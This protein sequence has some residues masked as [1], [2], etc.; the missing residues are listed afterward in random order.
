M[1]D[2]PPN[3]TLSFLLRRFQEAG[4]RPRTRL[5]QNFLIDMN[6]QRVLL[7]TAL[8]GPEDVVLE[9]GTGTGALTALMAREAAAVVTVELDRQLFQL[10]GEELFELG[11]VTMLQADALENKNRLNPDV[12]QAVAAQLAAGPARR[13][14]LVANLPYQVATPILSNLL[15][16]ERP[17]ESMTCTVQKEVAERIIA[18]PGTKDYGA[19]AVWVQSQCRAELVRVLAPSV[20]WPRPKVSS[21]FLHLTLEPKR[22][23]AI[24]DV[25]F[26]HD[27]VRAVF[28]HRR[29]LL[30]GEI[31]AALGRQATKPDADRLLAGLGLSATARAEELDPEQLLALCRAVGAMR[32]QASGEAGCGDGGQLTP[33]PA[34]R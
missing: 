13:F 28:L 19:L 17:P 21:A 25:A 16:L 1:P 31:H 2:T 26:F 27:F 18:R 29:K 5:G 4:I 20:F 30:R 11:N 14:K 33:A 23:E 8:L 15:A 10:A 7:K 22:R 34:K 3:Q 24:P 6:L 32:A 9:I 12:L